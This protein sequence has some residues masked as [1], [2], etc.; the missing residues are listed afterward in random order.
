MNIKECVQLKIN[1][2]LIRFFLENPASIDNSR[3]IATWINEGIEDTENA[4]KDLLAAKL[5]VEHGSEATTAYG[6]TTNVSV[7]KKTKAFLKN[8]KT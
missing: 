7:I 5:L 1:R 8:L 2:K 3:G 4:L 6:L